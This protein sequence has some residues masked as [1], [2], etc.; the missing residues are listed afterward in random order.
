MNLTL[1]F[2]L[3]SLAASLV[4]ALFPEAA[5][6]RLPGPETLHAAPDYRGQK[7]DN[8]AAAFYRKL[9]FGNS[10]LP[11][12]SS[13]GELAGFYE[14]LSQRFNQEFDANFVNVWHEV[15]NFGTRMRQGA[16]VLFRKPRPVGGVSLSTV[17]DCLALDHFYFTG[18]TMML[19]RTWVSVLNANRV[20]LVSFTVLEAI[21]HEFVALYQ[22]MRYL[23]PDTA[24]KL[25]QIASKSGQF[26]WL[27]QYVDGMPVNSF[28][29]QLRQE[30][31]ALIQNAHNR[32]LEFVPM[33]KFLRRYMENPATAQGPLQGVDPEARLDY[34]RDL[35]MPITI[36][37]VTMRPYNLKEHSLQELL[38]LARTSVSGLPLDPLRDAARALGLKI[39]G[40]RLYRADNRGMGGYLTLKALSAV[41]VL[42]LRK[43][44]PTKTPDD[45][46]NIRTGML[47]ALMEYGCL[48]SMDL[49]DS[50]ISEFFAGKLKELTNQEVS[51]LIS[52]LLLIAGNISTG[53]AVRYPNIC[54]QKR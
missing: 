14:R 18:V 49:K 6:K 41:T 9:F 7:N 2:V 23:S 51:V 17:K 8:R 27:R 29:E 21:R 1:V 45:H 36:S 30:K 3:L 46:L 28:M 32:G 24:S 38:T 50:T 11:Y 25:Q 34:P 52:E 22:R 20:D 16:G 5:L 54:L 10:V 26:V 33:T 53:Q 39:L 48:P 4:S 35:P 43:A 19:S 44:K 12:D 37:Y 40:L 15:T 31:G 47:A 13:T 42:K